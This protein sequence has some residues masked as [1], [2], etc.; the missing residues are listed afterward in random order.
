MFSPDAMTGAEAQA[1]GRVPEFYRRKA[2]KENVLGNITE[3]LLKPQLEKAT[4]YVSR[5]DQMKRMAAATDLSDGNAVRKTFNELL[6]YNPKTAAAWLKS[7]EPILN[8]N[9]EQDKL[10]AAVEKEKIKSQGD[11]GEVRDADVKAY[12]RIEKD[13]HRVFA[14]GQKESFGAGCRVQDEAPTSLLKKLKEKEYYDA[15][16]DTYTVPTLE[17]Y[18]KEFQSINPR[19][20]S[21]FDSVRSG[22]PD[23]TT[24]NP[25]LLY[26]SLNPTGGTSQTTTQ[27]S[28]SSTAQTASQDSKPVPE[29]ARKNPNNPVDQDLTIK[30]YGLTNDELAWIGD[31]IEAENKGTSFEDI[32]LNLEQERLK[33]KKIKQQNKDLIENMDN[34]MSN[35]EYNLGA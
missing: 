5:P 17:Q 11:L 1:E 2:G 10:A 4:G 15:E 30:K 26:S 14:C 16:T 32:K 23:Y 28:D 33:R 35:T 31:L 12:D 25:E 13:Y 9:L 27:T 7:I 3:G 18:F 6:K 29:S 22:M 19:A 8:Q 24:M 34:D 21:I 20:G